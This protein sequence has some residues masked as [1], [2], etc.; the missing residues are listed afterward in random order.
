MADD[1]D[2]RS[3][4]KGFQCHCVC[5]YRSWISL[6]LFKLYF[7]LW[8]LCLILNHCFLFGSTFT[9]YDRCLASYVVQFKIA[10]RKYSCFRSRSHTECTVNQKASPRLD[11]MK[12]CIQ[13]SCTPITPLICLVLWIYSTYFQAHLANR[14]Q[15]YLY[16]FAQLSKTFGWI[17]H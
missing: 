4:T 7:C 17:N 16:F 3:A 13:T 11:S 1:L 10:S 9:N 2:T 14:H 12:S 5:F 8:E 6:M 15:I